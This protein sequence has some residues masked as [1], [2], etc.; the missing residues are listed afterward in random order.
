MHMAGTSSIWSAV[1]RHRFRILDAP[2][3]YAPDRLLS[4]R[5]T[6]IH[7][8]WLIVPC[9]AADFLMVPVVSSLRGPPREFAAAFA[10]GI[11]GC[12]LAQGCL[13]A[14]WLAWSDGPFLQRL[15]R[16]WLIASLLYAVWLVGLVLAAPT[17]SEALQVAA[18]V[19][20]GIPLVSLAAQFPPWVWRQ[21][22][23]W[24]LVR[25]TAEPTQPREAELTQR[26][27]ERLTIRNLM[28]A[29]LVVA[30]S[31]AL[32]RL[33][34]PADGKE[35]W[36]IW[37]IAC[38]IA[39]IVS[40]ISLLPA[41]VFLLRPRPLG[42]GLVSSAVYA[43]SWISL[44]WIVVAA[45]W[46]FAPQLLIPRAIYIGLSSLMLTF[47]ATLTLAASIAKLR[48]YRLTSRRSK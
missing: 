39:G 13:L 1:T 44:I 40:A 31:L 37:A 24:R 11:V 2:A 8:A 6:R 14:A 20:L 42:R 33:A 28:V 48:G 29:T 9:F 32:A 12:V 41:G 43:A 7:L 18:T 38:T 17:D 35:V 36:S 5:Q 3:A 22:W 23:G 15:A 46:W 45:K 34:V 26:R 47:A 30:A 10:F 27:N 21:L 4:E 25:E 16:H 19:A